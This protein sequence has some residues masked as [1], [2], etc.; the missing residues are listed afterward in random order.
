MTSHSPISV[1]SPSSCA[2]E[3]LPL[4]PYRSL[5]VRF[6]MLLGEDDFTNLGAYPR[7]K[8]WLHNAWLHRQGVVW[9]LKV[10]LDPRHGEIK[11]LPGLALDGLGRE[12]HLDVPMCVNLGAWL[13]A[14][15]PQP[16]FVVSRGGILLDLHL[17]IR[18][19][20]CLDRQVPALSEPCEGSG[21]TTAHSRVV[22]QVEILLRPGLAPARQPPPLPYHRLRLLFGLDSAL[23]DQGSRP[24]PADQLVLD[25]RDAIAALPAA[26]RPLA[27]LEAFR[28]FAADDVI[29][30]EPAKDADG[31]FT[32]MPVPEPGEL[33]LAELRQL[34]LSGQKGA[35][36]IDS[37]QEVVHPEVRYSHVATA[38]IEE[39]LCGA[40]CCL[41]AATPGSP[42][43]SVA[44]E[45]RVEPRAISLAL[46]APLAEASLPGGI[47]VTSFD[48]VAGWKDVPIGKI[49][50]AANQ[51]TLR[52]PADLPLGRLRLLLRGS[53]DKPLLGQDGAVFGAKAGHPS[54]GN[55][56]A[57]MT[58]RK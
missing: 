18:F 19:H 47:A 7:G 9:G 26:E 22:E 49:E 28:R 29:E 4:D 32:L 10:E 15:A 33:V 38:T 13:D 55:D 52:F 2:G 40:A 42:G 3:P 50:A 17:V 27:L 31:E 36:K 8:G 37:T 20:T 43:P 44:G 30:L 46:T 53:G 39:L 35:W 1:K 45:V 48:A 57:F 5:R 58:E 11:V 21:S 6:G 12:L 16:P 51:L 23:L 14:Q 25:A 24:T 41:T 34:R 56:F 54:D